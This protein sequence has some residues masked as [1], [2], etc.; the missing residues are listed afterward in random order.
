MGNVLFEGGSSSRDLGPG[1]G[2]NLEA[3]VGQHE[4]GKMNEP[5]S[6]VV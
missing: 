3:T 4:T 2:G 5:G 6:V 1:A